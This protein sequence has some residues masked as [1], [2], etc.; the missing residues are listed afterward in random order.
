MPETR[1]QVIR[2]FAFSDQD[3]PSSH[4]SNHFIPSWESSSRESGSWE[5]SEVREA[6]TF[7]GLALDDLFRFAGMLRSRTAHSVR[8]SL[9][10]EIAKVDGTLKKC[11]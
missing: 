5:S 8:S 4:S 11:V 6:L 3:L 1:G 2:L 7:F 9:F 10:N